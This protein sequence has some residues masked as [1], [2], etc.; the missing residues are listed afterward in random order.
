MTL[1]MSHE[2]IEKDEFCYMTEQKMKDEGF[3]AAKIAGIIRDNHLNNTSRFCRYEP[4]IPEFLVQGSTN[5]THAR[6]RKHCLSASADVDPA[7]ASAAIRGPS[8]VDTAAPVTPATPTQVPATPQAAEAGN[9]RGRGTGESQAR[10][11]RGGRQARG[12]KGQAAK[13]AR[14][15]RHC[16]CGFKSQAHCSCCAF[17]RLWP[18]SA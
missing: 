7:S 5:I 15:A 16:G 13:E 12:G 2:V 1:E 11:S 4:S 8:C 17:A 10:G 3:N 9:K 6:K 18:G 14:L